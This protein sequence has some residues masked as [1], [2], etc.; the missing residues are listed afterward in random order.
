[1]DAKLRDLEREGRDAPAYSWERFRWRVELVRLGR[2]DEAGFLVGDLVE[3]EEVTS[4]ELVDG[5]TVSLRTNKERQPWF[6]TVTS[7]KVP[8]AGGFNPSSSRGH[9]YYKDL[10]VSGVALYGIDR[11]TLLEPVRPDARTGLLVFDS[12]IGKVHVNPAS[13]LVLEGGRAGAV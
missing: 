13:G 10:S 12:G 11:V 6:G 2:P 7:T 3:V 5:S 8:W 9:L 1:M 4:V